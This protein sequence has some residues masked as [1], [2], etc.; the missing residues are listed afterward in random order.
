MGVSL[1]KVEFITASR[2]V[3]AYGFITL[4]RAFQTVGK[5]KVWYCVSRMLFNTILIL[6]YAIRYPHLS[7]V[8]HPDA[9]FYP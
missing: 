4:A 3:H 7:S 9:I 5:V 1:A 6:F 2:E 8:A